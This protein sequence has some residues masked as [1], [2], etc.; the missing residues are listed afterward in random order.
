MNIIMAANVAKLTQVRA[1]HRAHMTRL[2]EKVNQG[3]KDMKYDDM[4]VLLATMKKKYDVLEKCDADMLDLLTDPIEIGE[5][6]ERSSELMD[7]IIEAMTKMELG[8]DYYEKKEADEVKKIAVKSEE[9]TKKSAVTKA[10]SQIKLPK[11]TLKPY[12]GCL[13][14]WSSFWDQFDASIHSNNDLS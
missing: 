10:E 13:L 5:E 9:V 11:F 6:I 8:I 2:I 14:T 12:D 4:K 3:S 1:G 7:T